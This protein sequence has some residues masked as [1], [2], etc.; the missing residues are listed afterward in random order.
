MVVVVVVITLLYQTLSWF[1]IETQTPDLK[2]LRQV[3]WGSMTPGEVLATM[4]LLKVKECQ[5]SGHC[6]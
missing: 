1:L 4:V 3:L 5:R 6:M 2:D